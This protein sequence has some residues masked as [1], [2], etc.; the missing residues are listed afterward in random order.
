VRTL[1]PQAHFVPGAK[2]LALRCRSPLC[3]FVTLPLCHSTRYNRRHMLHRIATGILIAVAILTMACAVPF[4]PSYTIERQQILVTFAPQTPGRVHVTSTYRLK[5]TGALDLSGI[6]VVLPLGA[7]NLRVTTKGAAL[8]PARLE[9]ALREKGPAEKQETS[10]IFSLPFASPLPRKAK[11]QLALEFDVETRGGAFYFADREWYFALLPPDE[12]LATGAPRASKTDLT[13]RVPENY[14]VL[15]GGSSRGVKRRGAER[16]FR[17]H[18]R[19]N[20]FNLFLLAGPYLEQKIRAGGTTIILLTLKPL[21]PGEA[22][23]AAERITQTTRLYEDTLGPRIH[24]RGPLWVVD[25]P[26]S[27]RSTQPAVELAFMSTF[28]QGALVNLEQIN[29]DR[30]RTSTTGLNLSV[31]LDLALAELWF[32]HLA[33][34]DPDIGVLNLA[35]SAYAQRLARDAQ[36]ASSDRSTFLSEEIARFDVLLGVTKDTP[37]LSLQPPISA[38]QLRPA[39]QKAILFLFALEEKVGKKN[40]LAAVKR[41]IQALRGST[42]GWTE[43]RSAVEA[44]SA[45]D[46]ASMFRDWLNQSGIPVDFRSRYASH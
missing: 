11:L 19:D 41:M 32:S 14:R 5:N 8:T 46:L 18:F 27:W 7:H 37:I 26:T 28:P 12:S 6:R 45:Q 39:R 44:E 2:R 9:P 10:A 29:L 35:L 43:L 13:V 20:D 16:E 33:T 17:F 40:L 1:L 42:Y 15:S 22:Q 21:T 36:G 34:P 23:R 38:V 3:H 25:F 24:P 4:G 31:S 30:F